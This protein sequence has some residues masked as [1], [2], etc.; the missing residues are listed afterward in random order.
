MD[1]SDPRIRKCSEISLTEITL[2]VH[3]LCPMDSCDP[4]RGDERSGRV[5]L[6]VAAIA[7]AQTTPAP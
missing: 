2:P 1:A 5:P 4:E 7:N 6:Y 3:E